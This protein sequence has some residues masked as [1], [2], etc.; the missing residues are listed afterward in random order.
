MYA[1]RHQFSHLLSQTFHHCSNL[2][3][4]CCVYHTHLANPMWVQTHTPMLF[5]T[6]SSQVHWGVLP[7]HPYLSFHCIISIPIAITNWNWLLICLGILTLSDIIAILPHGML[8]C[9]TQHSHVH[10][11]E[12]VRLLCPEQ[13]GILVEAAHIKPK[14]PMSVP[15][16]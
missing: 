10:L 7:C 3:D 2:L 4:T 8:K 1:L 14:P 11:H 15:M 13:Q 16:I 5:I 12:V 6:G 9:G